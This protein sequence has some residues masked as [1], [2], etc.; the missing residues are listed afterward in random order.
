MR[1]HIPNTAGRFQ[2]IYE[3]WIT[4][5]HAWYDAQGR[6]ASQRV[7]L[8]RYLYQ[9]L[10]KDWLQQVA[11]FI[12]ADCTQTMLLIEA[13]DQIT[14]YPRERRIPKERGQNTDSSPEKVQGTRL[15]DE[16]RLYQP[17]SKL[18]IS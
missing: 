7:G 17:D 11:D 9:E 15:K 10:G 14:R 12:H 2:L 13:A 1:I 3:H 6:D 5:G 8:K 16:L 18:Q 4:V